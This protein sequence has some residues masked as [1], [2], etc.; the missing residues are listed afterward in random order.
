ML[1]SPA[2]MAA[3]FVI[4]HDWTLRTAVRAELRELGVEALGIKSAEDVGRTLAAGG[5]PAAVVLEATTD[6]A[7]DPAVRKLVGRVPT[8]IIA[9]RT[10][11]LPLPG[12]ASV[13]YRPVRI[14]EIV[15]RVREILQQG[16]A[17]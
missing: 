16:T 5:M 8:I 2:K 12:V 13:F 10:E 17:A 9:S 1:H 6:L 11:S 15:T 14:A 7:G 3:V 4:A